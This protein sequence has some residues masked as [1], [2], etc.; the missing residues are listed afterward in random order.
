[1]EPNT[2]LFIEELMQEDR[3]EINSLRTEMQD[4][5]I[6]HEASINN[7]VTELTTAVQQHEEHVAVLEST[8]SDADKVLT[9]WKPKVDASL[10]TIKL[11]LSKFNSFFTREGKTLDTSSPGVLPGGSASSRYLSGFTAAVPN[12]HHMEITHRDCGSRVVYT[13]IHDPIKGML[14]Q[15]PPPPQ[16][17]C[18][19]F[20]GFRDTFKHQTN[21]GPGSRVN[22]GKLPKMIFFTFEYYHYLSECM[23]V[24]FFTVKGPTGIGRNC[25]AKDKV[26]F[27]VLYSVSQV[28]QPRNTPITS[29]NRKLSA[30]LR[31]PWGGGG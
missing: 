6:T 9:T 8:A 17:N 25:I 21:L 28:K 5:F 11:K 15:S 26:S 14:H 13:Q 1:M 27:T 12:G 18:I 7:C 29:R 20:P 31:N 2:K 16:S 19:E 3:N 10:S 22:L 23:C 30:T 4:K 24:I